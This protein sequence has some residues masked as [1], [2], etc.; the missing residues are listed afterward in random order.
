MLAFEEWCEFVFFA[1]KV[2]LGTLA[3]A[4]IVGAI[5]YSAFAVLKTSGLLN[6]CGG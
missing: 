6:T 3:A 1:V 5:V 2:V 4:G